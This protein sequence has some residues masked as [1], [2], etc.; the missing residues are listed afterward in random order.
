MYLGM[1]T[2]YDIGCAVDQLAR[3]TSKPSKVHI[4]AAKHPLLI[5]SREDER[6]FRDASWGNNPDNGK[7]ISSYLGFPL[8]WPDQLC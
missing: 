7:S 1:V 5:R 3:A 2:R 8:V 4:A 6:C